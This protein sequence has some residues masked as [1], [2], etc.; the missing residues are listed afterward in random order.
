MKTIT[1][2][3]LVGATLATVTSASAQE[4]HRHDHEDGWYRFGAI[5]IDRSIQTY[6][7]EERPYEAQDTLMLPFRRICTQL[8]AKSDRS[9]S[10]HHVWAEFHGNRLDYEEGRREYAINNRTFH[11]PARSE[12]KDGVLFVP[13]ELFKNLSRG[14]IEWRR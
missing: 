5:F 13:F 4:R 10:G 3:F 8:G 2:L 11:I 7:R 6:S 12:G 9:K 14:R 1:A